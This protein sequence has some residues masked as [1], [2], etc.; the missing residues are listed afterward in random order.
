MRCREARHRL[1]EWSGVLS[2]LNDQAQ[3]RAHLDECPSCGRLLEAASQLSDAF[4]EAATP[5]MSGGKSWP[6]QMTEVQRLAGARNQINMRRHSLMKTIQNQIKRRPALSMSAAI[7]VLLLAIAVL[8]PFKF[9]RTIGYE[10]AVAGIDSEI[11]QDTDRLE[12]ALAAIG[13]AEHQIEVGNCEATC[14]LKISKLKTEGDVQLV[15]T[16]FRQIE[17]CEVKIINEETTGEVASLLGQAKHI[18]FVDEVTVTPDELNEAARVAIKFYFDY[19]KEHNMEL[20][21]TFDVKFRQGQTELEEA[22]ESESAAKEAPDGLPTEYKLL[23]NYPNPFNPTTEIS[24]QLPEAAHVTLAIYN[25]EGQQVRTLVDGVVGAGEHVVE[26]NATSDAGQRV[27]SGV[28]LYRLT[29]GDYT[30]S[31][32]MLL[33]K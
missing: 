30:E 31:R 12:A 28:Y 5:D 21:K 19:G 9:D 20:V 18:I 16:F 33:L 4:V 25:I 24:Y 2:D 13:L 26:W 14:N 7:A 6:E 15:T 1:N 11:A 29:A 17:G 3:L 32:K 10:L 27:A 22:G 8:I 23:A